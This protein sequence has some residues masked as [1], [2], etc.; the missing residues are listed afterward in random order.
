MLKKGE[1][2]CPVCG[3]RLILVPPD[4]ST[5]WRNSSALIRTQWTLRPYTVYPHNVY[6]I[7]TRSTRSG[8]QPYTLSLGCIKRNLRSDGWSLY[9]K[10]NVM[11]CS[12][13]MARL[14]LNFNCIPLFDVIFIFL[15]IL[16]FSSFFMWAFFFAWLGLDVLFIVGRVICGSYVKRNLSN[17]VPVDD[18]DALIT[19][20]T[21]LIMSPEGLPQ[22]WLHESN[23]FTTELNRQKYSIY[24]A[25]KEEKRLKFSVCGIN[26]EQKR[27]VELMKRNSVSRL[28]LTFEGKNAGTAQVLSCELPPEDEED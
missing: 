18:H 16:G 21:E 20:S 14:S 8:R 28:E 11:H 2:I 22:K 25:E 19:P 7:Q 3:K 1:R 6:K 12:E 26:G 27:F 23:I 24:L 5:V 4:T 17:F 15:L 10:T 13:C 9:N